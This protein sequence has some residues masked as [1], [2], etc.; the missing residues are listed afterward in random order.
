[1]IFYVIHGSLPTM[2][3]SSTA[4]ITH[5]HMATRTHTHTRTL[6]TDTHTHHKQVFTM[7]QASEQFLWSVVVLE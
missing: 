6:Y 3:S 2:H 7:G 5:I 4:T 1:M